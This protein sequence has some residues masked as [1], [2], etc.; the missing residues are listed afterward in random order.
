[1]RPALAPLVGL[2][3][4]AGLATVP[5]ASSQGASAGCGAEDITFWYNLAHDDGT[6]EEV[7]RAEGIR[8]G[9]SIWFQANAPLSCDG[10]RLT[11]VVWADEGW[12]PVVH[13]YAEARGYPPRAHADFVYWE[14]SADAPHCR[15][16]VELWMGEPGEGALVDFAEGGEGACDFAGPGRCTAAD[17]W[18]AGYRVTRADGTTLEAETL[19]DAELANADRIEAVVEVGEDCGGVAVVLSAYKAHPEEGSFTLFHE[20]S[21]VVPDGG[22]RVEVGPTVAPECRFVVILWLGQGPPV[23][24][25]DLAEGGEG[26]CDESAFQ[27]GVVEARANPDGSVTLSWAALDAVDGYV[28]LRA[29][30]D[31]EVAPLDFI[32]TGATAYTDTTSVAGETYVYVVVPVLNGVPARFCESVGVTAVPFFGAPL[33]GALALVGV[34]GAYAAMRRRG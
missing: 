30:G 29:E 33:L 19:Y 24:L 17:A 18:V 34:V 5:P 10:E 23:A 25:L 12:M 3:L 20:S 21:V 26:A 31:G 11:L 28:I 1:M 8:M 32:E 6:G 13:A 7:E 9:D 14:M 16:A 15:F 2:L 4:L 27:C 22:G